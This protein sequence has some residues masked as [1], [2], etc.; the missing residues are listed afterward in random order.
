MPDEKVSSQ[1][2]HT[3]P[4]LG[5][6]LL[7]MVANTSTSPTNYRVQVKNFLSQVQINLPQTDYSALKITASLTANANTHTQAAGD[8]TLMANSALT[9][10]A[11]GMNRYGVK[12][13]YIDQTGKCAVLGQ[14]AAGA[15]TLD[16]GN[17]ATVG[18]NTFGVI[19]QHFANTKPRFTAPQAFFGVFEDANTGQ[20]TK[21]LM[22]IGGGGKTVSGVLANTD[23]SVIFSEVGSA[24]ATHTVKI[25]INGAD[26]WLL[27]S[28]VAPI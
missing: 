17:S 16:T 3:T 2:E 14:V 15:F 27:G 8:F 24:H 6:D 10:I 18:S 25:R 21:Y 7:P 12:G 19:V 28:N 1:P 20:D 13:A 5:T 26:V 23:D 11:Q 9:T 22:D 4:V